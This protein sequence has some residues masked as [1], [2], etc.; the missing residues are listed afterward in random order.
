MA[1]F[2]EEAL[3][4][5]VATFMG[6]P[7]SLDL[8][9]A[10][11]AVLGVPFDCGTHPFRVGSRQGPR[12]IREQSG[13][14]RPFWAELGDLNAVERLGLV[15]RGDVKLTPARTEDAFERIEAACRI[16][17]EAGTIPVTMGGDGSVSLPQMR[18]AA[19]RHPGLVALHID[20]HTD[21]YPWVEPER[22]NAATQFTHAAEEQLVLASRSFHVGIRGTVSV[23]GVL[24]HTRGLG[25]NV[26]TFA[27]LMARG[28]DDVLAEIGAAM[29]GR[30]V[31]LCWDMDVFDPSCAPGVAT[32]VWGGFSA[33]EGLDFLRAIGRL[34]LDIVAVDVNTVSPPHDVNGMTAFLAAQVMHE[35]LV[36]VCRK[37]GLA[38]AADGA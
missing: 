15:D 34:G 12:A 17:H 23:P 32:P 38:G 25:Y 16:I 30:P 37:L 6:I 13:L 21:S 20:S 5:G 22:Y 31:Y 29:A 26:V 35:G 19:R 9:T 2:T 7:Y 8:A 18:A 33:R 3:H 36:L 28:I 10:R 24:G 11:A 27:E 4:A 1:S 14:V